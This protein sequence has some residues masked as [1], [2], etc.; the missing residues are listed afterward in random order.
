[1]F[2]QTWRKPLDYDYKFMNVKMCESFE[3]WVVARA[4]QYHILY[5]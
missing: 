1:M 5:F 4:I 3:I 2:S